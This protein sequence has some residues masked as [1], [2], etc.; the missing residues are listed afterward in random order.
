M[1]KRDLVRPNFVAKVRF[2]ARNEDVDLL[3]YGADAAALAARLRQRYPGSQVV[4]VA[5][6]DFVT[7]WAKKAADRLA[8]V[9]A[10]IAAQQKYDFNKNSIWGEL[11]DFL[12]DLFDGTCAYCECDLLDGSYG[13]VEHYRPKN[14]VIGVGGHPGYYWLAFDAGNYL[15]TCTR[16]NTSKSNS[17]PLASGSPRASAPGAEVNEQPL[18]LNPYHLD[19]PLSEHL[20]FVSA[21][22][23]KVGPVAKGVSDAGK[24]S[25]DLLDLNRPDLVPQRLHEQEKAAG[26]YFLQRMSG[27]NPPPVLRQLTAGTRP[28]SAAALAAVSFLDQGFP[29]LGG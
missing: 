25:I 3:L 22:A 26:E 21:T 7:G 13:A 23:D 10:A 9:E 28:F 16:C 4:A 24:A 14:P 27:L 19:R 6:Y 8:D 1:R 29:S 12:F 17:F 15:P 18:L 20:R 11:K 2:V 5:P